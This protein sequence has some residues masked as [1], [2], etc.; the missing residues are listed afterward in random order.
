MRMCYIG[1]IRYVVSK[2]LYCF[3]IFASLEE[4]GKISRIRDFAIESYPDYGN[5]DID[6]SDATGDD[7]DKLDRLNRCIPENLNN[8]FY[9]RGCC[10]I[11]FDPNDK[12]E[13]KESGGLDNFTRYKVK[14]SKI[15]SISP[16]N[17]RKLYGVIECENLNDLIEQQKLEEIDLDSAQ[18]FDKEFVMLRCGSNDAACLAGPVAVRKDSNSRAYRLAPDYKSLEIYT[19][20]KTDWDVCDEEHNLDLYAP[21]GTIRRDNVTTDTLYYLNYEA[22]LS[23]WEVML[24]Q[25]ELCNLNKKKDEVK[26]EIQALKAGFRTESEKIQKEFESSIHSTLAKFALEEQLYDIL[27]GLGKNDASPSKD[28]L[29]ACVSEYAEL[30]DPEI[31]HENLLKVLCARV[32]AHRSYSDSE[33]IN[34]FLC[35]TQGFLCVLSGPPG[36]GKSSICDILSH[37]LGLDTIDDSLKEKMPDG[38]LRQLYPNTANRAVVVQVQPGWSSKRDFIGY[39]NPL[40]HQFDTNNRGVYRALQISDAEC[41]AGNSCVPP[42]L[43]ILDEANLSQME[44]YWS[45]FMWACDAKIDSIPTIELGEKHSFR[46]SDSLRFLATIN[47]DHTTEMLSPRLID[48]AWVLSLPQP[49]RSAAAKKAAPSKKKYAP[50]SMKLLKDV[51]GAKEQSDEEVTDG[52]LDIYEVA[53]TKEEILKLES[54]LAACAESEETFDLLDAVLKLCNLLLGVQISPRV[55]RAVRGYCQTAARKYVN[56]DGSES[57]LLSKKQAVDFAVLQRVLP[58]IQ[59]RGNDYGDALKALQDILAKAGGKDFLPR[60]AEKLERIRIKGMADMHNYQYFT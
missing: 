48:R 54:E 9:V 7:K 44:Y 33:I 25:T 53:Q 41:E 17:E 43:V 40:T 56:E 30:C 5:I 39:Y 23:R 55:Y 18:R 34:L 45:D 42:N 60:T 4:N 37:A 19:F 2:D 15:K 31:N 21:V 58:Q 29:A 3:D 35:L 13:V 1:N 28:M 8:P 36:T 47:N 57:P 49:S 10:V 12:E 38:A 27:R 26:A 22:L 59:G 46:I 14:V 20:N 11:E 52:L 51:F 16:A 32:K 50:V 6:I 24:A